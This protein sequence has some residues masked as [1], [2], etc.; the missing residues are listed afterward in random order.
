[1][2]NDESRIVK[3]KAIKAK[4]LAFDALIPLTAFIIS[5]FFFSAEESLLI[6]ISISM[7]SLLIE[8]NW[9]IAFHKWF[10]A[11]VTATLAINLSAIFLIEL[12][13]RIKAPLALA[14]IFIA[15][16]A[17]LYWIVEAFKRRNASG[18]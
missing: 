1:M 18:G 9:D 15:E 8:T 2:K 17:I 13:G 6:A 14:P 16:Y 4:N 3:K 10:I 7:I 5:T 12:P 11:I